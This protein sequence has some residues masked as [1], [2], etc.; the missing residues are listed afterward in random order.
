M[1][2]PRRISPRDAHDLVAREGYLY[3]DVRSEPEFADAHPEGAYNVPLAHLAAG[4]L[5]DNGD[6]LRVVEAAFP[7]AA[8]LVVG[9]KSGG[10][11]RRAADL[12]ARA[13]YDV[14]DQRAGFD[15][16]RDAFGAVVEPG[17]ARAGLPVGRGR[18]PGR[19][20]ADLRG[21]APSEP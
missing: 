18:P 1:P 11:S 20:Y 5:V 15:G 2:A 17:W 13:G 12:L 19:C 21:R 4:G 16:V 9:C 14:V 7:K 8:R 10:R 3:L 6:F